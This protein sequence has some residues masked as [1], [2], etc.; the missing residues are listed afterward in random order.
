MSTALRI[1][2]GDFGRVALLDMD[3]SLVPHA[4]SQC[5]VLLKAS[6]S[7]TYFAVRDRQQP[8]TDRTAVL[9]N[10]WEPH[11]YVHEPNAPDTVILALYIEPRWLARIQ[12]SLTLSA[13]PGFF[14]RPC[15]AIPQSVRT[16][17]DR[18]IA[19]MLTV[20]DVPQEHVEQTIFEL[21]IDVV[22]R[23]SEWRNRSGLIAP[24]HVHASDARI[25][26]AIGYIRENLG[27]EID[28]GDLAR[29]SHLSRAHFFTLF[30][31]CT[32]MTPNVFI[33]MMRMDLACQRLA[34]PTAGT[35]GNLSL[36]L[37][38]SEQSHFTRFFRQHIGV[39]P[40]QYRRI[41]D[42]YGGGPV[43]RLPPPG[44]DSRV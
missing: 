16:R 12:S 13:A 43:V 39:A 41:V 24:A 20:G 10:A 27:S 19:D 17:A 26:R 6:G 32:R 22:E 44:T 23:F 18:L 42:L 29:A 34:D 8:L 14:A 2:Q 31:R 33:N 1:F 5:H 38:F 36:D 21:M 37:G 25:R 28:M 40:S 15:V 7:D 11:S 30:R 4:H 35:L 3:K 9:V